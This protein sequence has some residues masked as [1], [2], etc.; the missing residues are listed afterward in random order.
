MI[1]HEADMALEPGERVCLIGR[2]GAGKS[3]TFKLITGEI[4]CDAGEVVPSTGLVVS[5]LAQSLPDAV[6][7]S[8][9]SIVKSGLTGIQVL[10]DQYHQRSQCGCLG[11]GL[12]TV[13]SI[14]HA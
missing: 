13:V 7:Q 12:N 8:V 1:L 9:R 14:R 3:T 2:N 5:Q 10:L 4:D 6:D 11:P